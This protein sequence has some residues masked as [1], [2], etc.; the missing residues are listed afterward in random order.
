MKTSELTETQRGHMAWRLDHKT[1]CGL[2]TALRVA[3]MEH[4]DP[5]VAEVFE[6]YGDRSPRSAK[7]QATKCARFSANAQSEPRSH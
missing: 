6:K 3:R 2:L 5:D 1:P 4:G 7:I